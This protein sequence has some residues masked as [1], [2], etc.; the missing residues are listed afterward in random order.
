MALATSRTFAPVLSQIAAMELIEETL[1]AKK[2][3]AISFE[4]SLLQR[5]VV[6]ILFFGT[7][8]K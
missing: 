1:W 4:S 2:A 7:Q 6:I 5:F 8:L 3:L